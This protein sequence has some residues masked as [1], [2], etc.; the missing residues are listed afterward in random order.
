MAC[1]KV[2]WLL[3]QGRDLAAIEVICRLHEDQRADL[4]NLCRARLRQDEESVFF[5]HAAKERALYEL[6]V[7]LVGWTNEYRPDPMRCVEVWQR[8]MAW[9]DQADRAERIV[10]TAEHARQ[11]VLAKRDLEAAALLE[12]L[13]EVR[14]F[15]EAR[16]RLVVGWN[17]LRFITGLLYQGLTA[18][19]I[20]RV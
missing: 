12:A 17:G 4:A 11:L 16:P 20:C 10:E 19:E 14:A 1:E 3:E 18:A 7:R 9:R 5:R 8:L 13:P 15:A 6:V 2:A